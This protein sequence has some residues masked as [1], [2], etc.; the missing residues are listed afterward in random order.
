MLEKLAC[1]FHARE[2]SSHA[3]ERLACEHAR[4]LPVSSPR[5]S[6]E[7]LPVERLACE[8]S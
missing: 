3:R 8:F 5:E 7:C 6:R 1:E 2:V 4:G